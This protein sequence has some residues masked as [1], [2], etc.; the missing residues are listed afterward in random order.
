[1]KTMGM[2]PSEEQL[3]VPIIKEYRLHHHLFVRK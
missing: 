2:A 1:M 3:Q